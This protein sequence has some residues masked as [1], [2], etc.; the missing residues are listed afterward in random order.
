MT[1][2]GYGQSL[3]QTQRSNVPNVCSGVQSIGR[4]HVFDLDCTS[5]E[6][7]LKW[8]AQLRLQNIGV[9]GYALVPEVIPHQFPDLGHNGMRQWQ[10]DL[11]DLNDLEIIDRQVLRLL[12]KVVESSR[13]TGILLVAGSEK[14]RW[15]KALHPK[16]RLDE[17]ALLRSTCDQPFDQQNRCWRNQCD[18]DVVNPER[19]T[20]HVPHCRRHGR[21]NQ[22]E[23]CTAV[24]AEAR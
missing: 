11:R 21:A 6:S 9:G 4:E 13:Q 8:P 20:H 24:A 22:A 14:K 23:R 19:I 5:L 18:I 16:L 12:E 1:K 3:T 15:S 2:T 10:R 7:I 17:L